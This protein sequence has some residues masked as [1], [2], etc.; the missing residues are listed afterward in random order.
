M[1]SSLGPSPAR[2]HGFILGTEPTLASCLVDFGA[3]V[4]RSTGH[5]VDTYAALTDIALNWTFTVVVRRL[6]GEPL[7]AS[8]FPRRDKQTTQAEVQTTQVEVICIKSVLI[9]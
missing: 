9:M 5:V 3:A 4:V 7:P 8:P 2:C 6:G 1:L